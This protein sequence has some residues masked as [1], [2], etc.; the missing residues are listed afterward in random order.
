M[1]DYLRQSYPMIEN[2]WRIILP[3]SLFITLFMIIFQPFGLA[4]YE[5]S[6]K[7]LLLAGYGMVTFMVLCFNMFLIPARLSFWPQTMAKMKSNFQ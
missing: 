4:D 2:R 7:L 5:G 1:L 3:I 6:D